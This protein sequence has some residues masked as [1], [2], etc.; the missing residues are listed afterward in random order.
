MNF[1]LIASYFIIISFFACQ[2]QAT[3]QEDETLEQALPNVIIIFADDLGYG[4]L[5]CYGQ[6]NY[7]TP[8]LDQM[9]KEGIRLTNFYVAQPVCSASRASLLTGC[10][11]NRVGVSGAFFPKDSVGLSPEETTLAEIVKQK[12]YATAIYGKWHLGHLPEFLPTRQGFDEYFGVPYSNDMWAKHPNNANFQFDDLP[13]VEN[14]TTVR[15]LAENQDSLTT[16]Y[17]QRAVSFIEKNKNQPFFLYLAHS[18]PHVPLYV[19]D[20][21]RGKSGAGLYGDVIQEIDWS[22]GQVMEALKN[23]GIEENTLVVFTSDNGPW[24]SYGGHSGVTGPLREGKGTVLEGGIR[25]PFIAK[26]PAKIPKGIVQDIPAATIDLLPT[27]ANWIGAD[28]PDKEVDG[29]NISP[30]LLGDK[31]AKN[32][33]EAYYFYYKQNELQGMLSGEGRWKLYFPHLYRSLEGRE[34]HSDGVPIDYNNRVEMGLELYDLENDISETK[35]IISEH[36]E[37]AQALQKLADPLRMELGDQLQDK[38]GNKNRPLGR[39]GETD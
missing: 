17:T 24:L 33:H 6:Q 32:P 3:I 27:I 4:D 1:K 15:Y 30:I 25:V 34:G 5:S 12:D 31:E 38:K 35:N 36:P 21:F 10:Y 37:Q 11:A 28:S 14:E 7:Q 13:I 8:Y 18:M 20:K 16:W 2:Q 23:N 26:W 29:K 19:S 39:F 22:T 9:S